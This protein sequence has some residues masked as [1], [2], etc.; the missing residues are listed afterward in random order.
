M[1]GRAHAALNVVRAPLVYHP[2]TRTKETITYLQ[3]SLQ[4]KVRGVG[5]EECVAV[6]DL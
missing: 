4:G 2:V 3:A 5:G 6:Q 1:S